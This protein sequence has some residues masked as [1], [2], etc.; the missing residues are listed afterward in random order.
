[1]ANPIQ[2]R[3]SMSTTRAVLINEQQCA[4]FRN[5]LKTWMEV[6]QGK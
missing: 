3:Y 6:P 5:I 2:T 1:M 4:L